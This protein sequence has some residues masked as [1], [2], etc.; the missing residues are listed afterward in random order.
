MFSA[1]IL[2]AGTGTRM[3]SDKAKVVHEVCFKPLVQWVHDACQTAGADNIVTVVG[4]NADQVKA[5]LGKDKTYALQDQQLGTGHAVISA[6]PQIKQSGCV[7]IMAG[8]A[9]MIT[10]QTIQNVVKY[11]LNNRLSA[12]ILSAEMETPFG[13][14]RIVRDENDNV[15]AIVEEKEAT[16]AQKLI[17]EIN[18]G[19]YC[20]DASLLNAALSEISNENAGG[21]Y[22]LTD[23]MEILLKNGYN[24]GAYKIDDA[25]ETMGINDRKH[26]AHVNNMARQIILD[27]HMENGVTIIDPQNTYIGA[28]VIIG[29]DTIIYPGC[30]IQGSSD[31]AGDCTIGQNCNLNNVKIGTGTSIIS[32]VAQDAVIGE[33]ASV[34]PFAYLRPKSVVGN[35]TKIGDFVEIKNANIGDG[36]KISH[37]TYIGDS[38]VGQGVNFGCGTVTVNYDSKKKYRTVIGDNAFIGCNTNLVAPVRIGDGGYTA[39][40]STITE[41]VPANALAIARSQQIVKENWRT[42]KFGSDQK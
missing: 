11:H 20:F 41:D 38:D 9:P 36:T 10:P 34:G 24:I 3:K 25:E 22:Y 35:N 7:V 27:K 14:G 26:L 2:A 4:H 21:E 12:T 23:T 40:G 32:S 16:A 18:S 30:V 31:I 29:A 8:D 13:Y 28:D 33:N 39:A 19:L 42:K 1:I 15:R 6:M 37:L 5:C 17:T